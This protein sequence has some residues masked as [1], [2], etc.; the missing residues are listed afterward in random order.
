VLLASL[1]A[2]AWYAKG[3]LIYTLA[4]LYQV[5]AAIFPGLPP[6]TGR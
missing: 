1:L 6:P 3:Q 2:L 4:F 5:A